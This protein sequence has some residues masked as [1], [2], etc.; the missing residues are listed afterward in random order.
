MGRSF[1]KK[2]DSCVH[3]VGPDRL[4]GPAQMGSR[5]VCRHGGYGAVP[6]TLDL[7]RDGDKVCM[8]VCMCVHVYMYTCEHVCMSVH[9]C[10]YARLSFW[11]N[12]H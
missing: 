7:E 11:E 1:R 9:E 5:A 12:S 3:R 6:A 8:C 4:P 10:A 2:G